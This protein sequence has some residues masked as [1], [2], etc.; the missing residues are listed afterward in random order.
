MSLK[1]NTYKSPIAELVLLKTENIMGYSD[2]GSGVQSGGENTD[3][4]WGPL[5]PMY[6]A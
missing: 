5:K 3:S 2:E 1:S 4:G 6:R